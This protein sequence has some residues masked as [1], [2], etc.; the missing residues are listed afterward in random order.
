L[1]VAGH[2]QG[3]EH[4]GQVRLDRVALVVEHGP[5]PQVGLGHPE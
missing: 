1:E 2:G 3:G 4:D 5:G